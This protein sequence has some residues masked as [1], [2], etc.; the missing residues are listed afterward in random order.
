MSMQHLI[1]LTAV[2]SWEGRANGLPEEIFAF[3]IYNGDDAATIN[4]LIEDQM[5]AFIRSQ[6]MFAQR[7]QGAIIDVR[8]SPQDR[9]AVPFRWI[10]KFY[11]TVTK[12]TGELSQ[13]DEEEVERLED[14]SEPVKQ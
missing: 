4:K 3:V 9:I 2:I 8:I 6:M 10:V 7:D 11:A 12:L 1:K 14:G 5:S 13:A